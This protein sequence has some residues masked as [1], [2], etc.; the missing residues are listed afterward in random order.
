V[1]PD[2]ETRPTLAD[3]IRLASATRHFTVPIGTPSIL[4]ISS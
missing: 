4:A 1:L 3:T 2:R